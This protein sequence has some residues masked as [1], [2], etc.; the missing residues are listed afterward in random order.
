[1]NLNICIFFRFRCTRNS[2]F[3]KYK[4][5][6]LYLLGIGIDDTFVMMSGWLNSEFDEDIPRRL[7]A[8]LKTSGMAITLTSL[9]DFVAMLVGIISVFPSIRMFCVYTGNALILYDDDL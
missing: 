8:T 2:Q 5:F 9:T 3:I 6:H 4:T 1:M 7:G